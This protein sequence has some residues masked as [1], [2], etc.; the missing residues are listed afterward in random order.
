MSSFFSSS[1][2][3]YFPVVLI[4]SFLFGNQNISGSGLELRL[5]I[6]MQVG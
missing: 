3:F 2:I 5:N 4:V 1:E 6:G